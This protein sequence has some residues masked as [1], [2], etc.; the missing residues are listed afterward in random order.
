MAPEVQAKPR[1]EASAKQF[2]KPNLFRLHDA[3]SALSL[4]LAVLFMFAPAHDSYSEMAD[5]EG[6]EVHMIVTNACLIILT[7]L[8]SVNLIFEGVQHHLEHNIHPVFRGVLNALNTELMGMGFLA[9]IVY[10]T[11]KSGI[12]L[13]V[14]EKVLCTTQAKYMING[15]PDPVYHCDEKIIHMF[16]D[17]HMSLF[18]VLVMYFARA[19]LLLFQTDLIGDD[20]EEM[21]ARLAEN[22]EEV[23]TNEYL[24]SKNDMT[25]GPAEKKDKQE[26]FEFMLFRKRFVQQIFSGQKEGQNMEADFSFADYLRLCCSDIAQEVV[27]IPPAEWMALEVFWFFLW[28]ALRQPMYLRI[29]FF[30][31][32]AILSLVLCF[33]MNGKMEWVLQQLVPQ[34]DKQKMKK[35]VLQALSLRKKKRKPTH[36]P[37]VELVTVTAPTKVHPDVEDE[38]G[39]MKQI[40]VGGKTITE[41]V[42]T[43]EPLLF[44]DY[45]RNPEHKHAQPAHVQESLFWRGS[46]HFSLHV[47]RFFILTSMVMFV[48]LFTM[49][50]F[51]EAMGGADLA[52]ICIPIP[53]IAAGLL[54][55]P[56]EM[57]KDFTITTNIEFM[58]RPKLVEKVCWDNRVKKSFRALKLL[59]TL[60]SN[61]FQN[62]ETTLDSTDTSTMDKAT[63]ERF[64]DLRET[65]KLFDADGSNNVDLAELGHLM[66]AL[67]INLDESE[68]QNIMKEFDV[69]GDGT[70]SFDEFYTMMNRRAKKIDPDEVVKEMFD[71][72]DGD[73]SGTVTHDEFR[74]TLLKTSQELT[75]RDIQNLIR[76]IDASGD[77][78]INIHEFSTALKR[79][80]LD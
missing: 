8:I 29:R 11:L 33:Q 38:E 9:I 59:R 54:L 40:K 64:M 6:K 63:L 13:T 76:E 32:Y 28:I 37:I 15:V 26:A 23:I 16:E 18:L 79:M 58:K 10:F 20:W 43:T 35:N 14:G 7:G 73:G 46:E 5:H 60:Q 77:G 12:L 48:L 52:M 36:K 19:I 21:E 74:A 75:E 22:G 62:Q 61:K 39:A 55:V 66:I 27:E 3:A 4:I 17:I 24:E 42:K 65:F 67:G 80:C 2:G 50:P 72:I 51:A 1:S 68:K 45:L 57:I 78:T 56:H 25:A 34:Y 47:L 49:I 53:F 71:M 30:L 70:I 69:S 44:T 31:A 41:V